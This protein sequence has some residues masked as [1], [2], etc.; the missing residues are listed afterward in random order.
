MPAQKKYKQFIAWLMMALA[1]AFVI[2][3]FMFKHSLISFT[4]KGMQHQISPISKKMFADSA[5]HLY[6]YKTNGQHYKYTLVEFSGAGCSIC[7]KMEIELGKLQETH[8]RS[9]NIVI[10]PMTE[11]EGLR[12]GKYYGVVMIPTQ[13]ILDRKGLEIFR[14]TG[15]ISK[16]ELMTHLK[17]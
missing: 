10:R 15:F 8:G 5:D 9:V 4:S 17:N 7:K 14:H 6:N 1:M 3:L 12:W 13:I 11:P 16:S 2:M